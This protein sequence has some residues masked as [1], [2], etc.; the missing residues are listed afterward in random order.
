MLSEVSLDFIFGVSVALLGFGVLLLL[1]YVFACVIAFSEKEKVAQVHFE[2]DDG[3]YTDKPRSGEGYSY[4]SDNRAS[5]ER[6]SSTNP[7]Y[8]SGGNPDL[9]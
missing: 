4:S 8:G 2:L 9:L 6:Y 1:A 3:H 7:R 5:N